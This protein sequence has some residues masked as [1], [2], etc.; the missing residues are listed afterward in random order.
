MDERIKRPQSVHF[1]SDL[2]SLVS[3]Q[4]GRPQ[5]GTS[6]YV[7]TLAVKGTIVYCRLVHKPGSSLLFF[8][9]LKLI[10]TY[11]PHYWLSGLKK[12][13]P[14]KS[15]FVVEDVQTRQCQTDALDIIIET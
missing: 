4:T 5:C 9:S 12:K 8:F 3:G 1:S 7:F 11:V 6:T 14:P 10:H 13:I 2:S 15:S